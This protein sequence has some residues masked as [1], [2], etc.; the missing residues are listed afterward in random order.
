M[1]RVLERCLLS[2]QVSMTTDS[3][4]YPDGIGDE[5]VRPLGGWRR[6][7][8]PLSLAVFGAVVLLALTG[9]LGHERQWDAQGGSTSLRVHMPEL[10]RNGE[11]LE[12]RITVES[13]EPIGELVVGIDQEIWEDVTV[14][15]LIPAAS[16]EESE[17]GEFR[18][19]FAELAAGT[20]FLLKVDAQ[21]NP[22]IVGGNGG[23]ITVYDGE[24]RL[25]EVAVEM[26]V[27]P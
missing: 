2:G 18:F 24:E 27:L 4:T 12:M 14:N 25:V 5:N 11:F 23:T 17:D 3:T 8:S 20:P 19:T 1:E 10:I 15:T 13:G 16:D 22:D 26:G 21:V 9:M 7:A 6:H